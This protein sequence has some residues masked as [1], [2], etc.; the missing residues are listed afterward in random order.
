M[1]PTKRF[2]FA[3][4][5][6]EEMLREFRARWYAVD[7]PPQLSSVFFDNESAG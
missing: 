5:H 4:M 6:L 2:F 3:V 1:I 7:F